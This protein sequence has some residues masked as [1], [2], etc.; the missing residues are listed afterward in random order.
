[1]CE[2]LGP[3]YMPQT[4]DSLTHHSDPFTAITNNRHKGKETHSL[5]R[6]NGYKYPIQIQITETKSF[7]KHKEPNPYTPLSSK[8]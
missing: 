8:K 4:S 3:F 6:S 2:Y 7:A 5:K 1:M